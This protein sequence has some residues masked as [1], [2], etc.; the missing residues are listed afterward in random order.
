MQAPKLFDDVAKLANGAV[1]TLVGMRTEV[2][3][4]VRQTMSRQLDKMDL[5]SREEFE[6][7]KAMAEKARMENDA[8]KARLDALEQQISQK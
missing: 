1:G 5:V 3:A 4:L 7:V 8:L 6:V 2:E